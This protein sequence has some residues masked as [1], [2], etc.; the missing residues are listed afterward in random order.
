MSASAYPPI[1]DY[2]LIGDCH[3][4]ALVSRTASLDWCCL[5]RFDGAA[6]FGRLLDRERGGYCSIEPV[7]RSYRCSREYLDDTLVLATTFEEAGGE[8]TVL[9]CFTMRDG[10][11]RNPHRQ[12]LRVVE[13]GRGAVDMRV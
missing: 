3:T 10:G 6:V 7:A 4:A 1:G 12:L 9:D 13:C 8:A 2:A 11:G 5:P